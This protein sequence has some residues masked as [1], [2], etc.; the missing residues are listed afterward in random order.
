M[1]SPSAAMHRWRRYKRSKWTF[2]S[3]SGVIEAKASL[4][5]ARSSSR[6]FGC[7]WY[8]KMLIIAPQKKSRGLRSGHR[9]G[10]A[11]IDPLSI[12]LGKFSSNQCL[13]NNEKWGGA[14]SCWNYTSEGIIPIL[15]SSG[16]RKSPNIS[17]YDSP[18]TVAGKKYGPINL[19]S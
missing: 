5:R 2:F 19:S 14:P 10:H 18:V 16:I 8:T 17:K 6:S 3:I 11:K 4:I 9:G 12:Q 15:S 1:C 7:T 13:T